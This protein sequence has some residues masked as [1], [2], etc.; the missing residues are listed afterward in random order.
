VA[1]SDWLLALHV[2]SAII[3]IASLTMLWTL[4]IA[5]RPSAPLIAPE[6]AKAFGRVGGP[7]VGVGM[8][9]AVIFG[10]WLAIDDDAYHIWDGWILASL[11]LWAISGAVG[12]RAGQTFEKDPVGG[13]AAGIRFQAISS[14]LIL[15]ILLLM[16]W[17]P[18][19]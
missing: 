11:I 19:A 2:L 8:M 17:K 4:I 15:A 10:I 9:G 13:R 7:L 14:V 3:V 18:G 12:G 6:S 16:I 1:F 5:T